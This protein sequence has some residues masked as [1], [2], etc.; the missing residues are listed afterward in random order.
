[1]KRTVKPFVVERKRRTTSDAGGP[2]SIWSAADG[3]EFRQLTREQKHEQANSQSDVHLPAQT[4]AHLNTTTLSASPAKPRILQAMAG[5]QTT[6]E[7]VSI[8]RKA[9]RSKLDSTRSPE[10]AKQKD[11]S[12]LVGHARVS[13]PI[14][15]RDEVKAYCRSMQQLQP[16][17]GGSAEA[18]R[19]KRMAA[20]NRLP[21]HERWKWDLPF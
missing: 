4:A 8:E 21:L 11:S 14:S 12:D 10:R 6:Y 17:D 9:Q 20:R 13:Q 1:M 15:A 2:S 5:D 18:R 16:A 3:N 19:A 7:S